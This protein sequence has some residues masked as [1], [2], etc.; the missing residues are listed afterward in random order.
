MSAIAGFGQNKLLTVAEK[1]DFRSTSEYKDVVEFIEK[2]RKTS[3]YIRVESIATSNEGRDIPLMVIGKHLPASPESLK[4]DPRIVIYIQGNIHAGEVEGKEALLMFARDLLKEK[5]PEIL[6]HAVILICPIFNPDGND[7]I[8]TNNRT[9]QNGPVNGVGV[10]HN[11]Q[12]L[13]L[14][15]DALKAES[16]EIRGLLVNVFN[17]WDPYVFMDCHTTNGS[18]HVEPVTFTW[19]VNPNGDKNLIAYMRDRMMPAMSETLLRKYKTENCFYG[20]FYDMLNPLKGWVMEASEPRYMT[21]YV[22]IRN[23]LSIL[24]ENYVYADFKSRVWGCYHLIFSLCDY[25]ENNKDE[26]RKIVE[27]AD[28]RTVERINNAQVYDSFA[29]EYAVRPVKNLVTI[30]TFEAEETNE[31]SEWKSYKNTGRQKTVTVPYYIDFYALKSVALPSA[32]IFSINDRVVTDLL[33]THGIKLVKLLKDTELTV[34][35]FDISELTGSPRLNQGHYMN[36]VKGKFVTEIKSFP[37]GTIIVKMDQPL[38]NVCAYLLEPQS[39]DGL[40]A[41]N[42]LD[43]YLVPQWGSG[44]YPYPVYR[45][46]GGSDLITAP[47]N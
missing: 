2:L 15:R 18:F 1:S 43:R 28:R 6:K 33:K 25:I 22:G 20:E 40:L 7:R 8:S 26:I 47:M 19:M 45:F 12:F 31:V 42:F 9:T 32:Y 35:R 23:R 27:A 44:Y 17:R 13:D 16:P 36:S 37:A 41:W 29:I 46:L 11:A 21:N 3:D 10:R 24:N 30:K 14:N 4:N 5:D 38:A 39:G 34:E